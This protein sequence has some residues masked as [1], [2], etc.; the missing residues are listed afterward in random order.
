MF[1]FLGR[2]YPAFLEGTAQ[3]II[4]SI[5]ASIIGILIGLLLVLMR[6]SDNKI[7]ETIYRVY[8]SIVRGTPSMIQVMLIYYSLSKVLSIPPIHI[9]GASLDRVLPGS[10]ALGLNSGAY[11]A[12]IFRS[13]II[14]IPKGQT[15]AGLSLGMTRHMVM[16]EIVLP[17]AVRNALPAMGNE[18]ISLIKESSVLF[19]IGVQE[20]TAQALGVGG[21]LYDFVPPLIVAAAVYFV[22]TFTLSWIIGYFEKK[23]SRKYT[24]LA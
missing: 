10:I 17:Q 12:E 9:L 14:S 11:T 15:E 18:F 3:T 21:T 1:D 6:I 7:L 19:Y 23:M 20:V 4:I 22:L 2:Y 5:I 8:I 13:G 24:R 16:F